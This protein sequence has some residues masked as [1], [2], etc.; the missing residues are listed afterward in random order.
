MRQCLE[1]TALSEEFA[2]RRLHG[3]SGEGL[4]QEGTAPTSLAWSFISVV[5]SDVM[6]AK[7][8]VRPSTLDWRCDI[9]E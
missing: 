2:Q 4:R 1:V 7:G 8:M 5:H 6:K 9:R 3:L